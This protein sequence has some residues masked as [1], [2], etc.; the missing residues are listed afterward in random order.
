MKENRLGKLIRQ[1]RREKQLSIKDFSALCG[2][3]TALVSQLERGIGNP[4]LSVLRA[5]AAT[6]GVSLSSLFV[7]EISNESLI[8]RALLT[9]GRGVVLEQRV[10]AESDVAVAAASILARDGFLNGMARLAAEFAM[11]LPRG[12]G[13]RVRTAGAAVLAGFGRE[14]FRRCAKLHFKTYAELC[15]G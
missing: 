14:A 5:I 8:R 15:G 3:S 2:I 13:P 4:S 6:L 11:E 7:G 9:R 12:A 10:R 1:Y